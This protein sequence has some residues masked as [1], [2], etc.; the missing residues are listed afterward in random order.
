M[1]RTTKILHCTSAS[2]EDDGSGVVGCLSPRFGINADKLERLPHFF[3]EF[4]DVEPF[5]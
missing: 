5:S 2:A 3:L 1:N 4:V